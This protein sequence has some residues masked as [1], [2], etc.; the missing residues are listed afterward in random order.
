MPQGENSF[1]ARFLKSIEQFNF[2]TSNTFRF[3]HAIFDSKF[4]NFANLSILARLFSRY[5]HVVCTREVYRRKKCIY[6][7]LE[8]NFTEFKKLFTENKIVIHINDKKY[9]VFIPNGNIMNIKFHNLESGIVDC[10]A[11]KDVNLDT[12]QTYNQYATNIP[13]SKLNLNES[14]S[15]D[16]LSEMSSELELSSDDTLSQKSDKADNNSS[17]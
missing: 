1:E 12:L 7:W 16:T 4:L 13:I 15:S 3:L 5:S 10:V 14:D 8:Q 2:Y 11:I 6:F 17:E 9:Y